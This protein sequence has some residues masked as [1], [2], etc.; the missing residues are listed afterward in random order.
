MVN[1]LTT[2]LCGK[3]PD[4]WTIVVNNLTTGLC[5]NNLTTGL[6]EEQPDYWTIV[7]NN[8]TPRFRRKLHDQGKRLGDF[9]KT[10]RLLTY[11]EQPTKHV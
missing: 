1:N 9:A 8:L 6:C 3:Q 11:M 2:G 5:G 7:V 4:Y 10:T